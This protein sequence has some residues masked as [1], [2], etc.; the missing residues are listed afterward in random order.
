VL[1][2][3]GI[4]S[5]AVQHVRDSDAA[6]LAGAVGLH[7]A[8][9]LAFVWYGLLDLWLRRAGP[10]ACGRIETWRRQN[11]SVLC[12][13]NFVLPGVWIGVTARLWLLVIALDILVLLGLGQMA[14][15]ADRILDPATP[16]QSW[17][18]WPDHALC[19]V[20]LVTGALLGVAL[21]RLSH[22]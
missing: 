2:F 20:L 13:T 16:S 3:L 1:L 19:A 22:P 11:R 6:A 10:E 4:F 14:Y 15:A 18:K 5:V 9:L 8:A 21:R 7:L 12:V 17:L